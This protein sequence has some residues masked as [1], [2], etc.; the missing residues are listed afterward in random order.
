MGSILVGGIALADLAPPRVRR[1]APRV[2]VDVKIRCDCDKSDVR[3]DVRAL[4]GRLGRCGGGPGD[5]TFT[6]EFDKAGKVK[7]TRSKGGL[8]ED[9]VRCMERQ[10]ETMQIKR[11]PGDKEP[12]DVKVRV[13]TTG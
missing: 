12:C 5:A 10:F 7:R 11:T 1:P 13:R 3:H 9:A 8:D 4:K 6:L 2:E